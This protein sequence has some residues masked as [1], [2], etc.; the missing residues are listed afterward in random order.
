[1]NYQPGFGKAVLP[2]AEEILVLLKDKVTRC[3]V[4]VPHGTRPSSIPQIGK[5]FRSLWIRSDMI[6]Y[7]IVGMLSGTWLVC[8]ASCAGMG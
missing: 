4:S 5:L 2:M 7:T 1:M 3:V 8:G 6:R